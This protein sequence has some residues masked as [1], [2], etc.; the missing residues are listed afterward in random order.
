MLTESVINDGT[1]T[2]LIM[3]DI[4]VIAV[5]ELGEKKWKHHSLL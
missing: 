2:G 1:E 3:P 5:V 4:P